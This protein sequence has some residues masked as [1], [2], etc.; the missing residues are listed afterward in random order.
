MS[1]E[2]AGKGGSEVARRF[3]VTAFPAV[4]GFPAEQDEPVAFEKK[5]TYNMLDGAF[6]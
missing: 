2:Q 1:R 4:L 3:G 5:P 6:P